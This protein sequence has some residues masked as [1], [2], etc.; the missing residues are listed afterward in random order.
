MLTLTDSAAIAIRDLTNQQE[1]PEGAGLRIA[2]DPSVGTLTLTLAMAPA[3]GDRVVDTS[4]ARIFLESDA[5]Q[6][7]DDKVLDAAVDPRGG[8]QFALAEQ[9]R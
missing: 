3:D 7:L 4:G 9:P 1:V 5:A 6:L 8:V 2:T